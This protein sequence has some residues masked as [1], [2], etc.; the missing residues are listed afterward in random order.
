MGEDQNY[1]MDRAKAELSIGDF[2]ELLC[3]DELGPQLGKV[4]IKFIR[5]M[6]TRRA[7][8]VEAFR[9]P[10]EQELCKWL[11]EPF[12]FLVIGVM[13]AEQGHKMGSTSA[14]SQHHHPR[15]PFRC[16]FRERRTHRKDQK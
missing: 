9:F 15:I 1:W 7:E 8:H 4:G 16:L 12:P 10:S 5:S 6:Y 13:A 11:L 3:C 14:P 2:A